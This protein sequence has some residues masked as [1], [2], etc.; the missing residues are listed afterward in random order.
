M[1]D[2][3]IV[4]AKMFHLASQSLRSNKHHPNASNQFKYYKDV[5]SLTSMKTW[6]DC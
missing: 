2:T 5:V 3:Y 4:Y 1:S 6:I